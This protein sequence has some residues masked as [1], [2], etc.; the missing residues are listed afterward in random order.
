MRDKSHHQQLTSLTFTS[1]VSNLLS[2]SIYKTSTLVDV[3]LAFFDSFPTQSIGNYPNY[4][5]TTRQAFFK[6]K[7]IAFFLA[8]FAAIVAAENVTQTT[9]AT[10]YT[11]CSVL[12]ATTTA[13]MYGTLM[14]VEAA[15]STS[16]SSSSSSSSIIKATH[17]VMSMATGGASN[18]GYPAAAAAPSSGAG[19][20][21]VSAS[22][23]TATARV[24]QGAA[25]RVEG[26]QII[27]AAVAG[28]SIALFSTW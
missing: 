10:Y 8:L 24:F 22:Q 21:T 16:A 18:S 5:T 23:P 11:T 6:M 26:S 13:T 25:S 4:H 2:T 14:P 28:L 19:N 12:Y 20:A 17:V 9:F 27:F 7:L 3:R 15:I 1:L